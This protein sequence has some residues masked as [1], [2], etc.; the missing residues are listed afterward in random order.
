VNGDRQ[1]KDRL[2]KLL[3]EQ[4]LCVLATSGKAGPYQTL[5]AFDASD[6][7]KDLCFM[8]PQHT[9]KY[10][11][12][13]A[14]SR[15]TALVDNRTNEESD[16][17]GAIAVTVVGNAAPVTG[18]EREALA[19]RYL[20]KHPFLEGYVRSPSAAFVRIRVEAYYIVSR[21]QIVVELRPGT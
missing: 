14:D 4:K 17:H 18:R 10:E 13:R 11:H 8:T 9:H 19:T 1:W 6:D 15:V 3:A 20:K 21:F 12:I 16:F 5:V 7:L 2:K